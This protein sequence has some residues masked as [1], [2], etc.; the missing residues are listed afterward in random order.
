VTVCSPENDPEFI[1]KFSQMGIS[2]IP[3]PL[4]RNGMNPIQDIYALLFLVKT[5]L[6]IKPDIVFSA[7][8]K[9]VIYGSL[10]SRLA[11]VPRVFSMISGAGYA[12][13][14]MGFKRKLINLL[15]RILFSQALKNNV[16]VFF[17]NPD[18]LNLFVRLG[19]VRKEQT[20]RIN[21]EGVD[22][23]H[24]QPVPLPQ[25]ASVYLMICRLVKDKG[26]VEY[27]E[28]ARLVKSRYPET[29]FNLLGPY[30]SNN[31]SA[32]APSQIEK[33]QQEGIINYCG[34][35]NDVRPFLSESSVFVLPSYYEGT[36]RTTLEAMA[37]G[38]PILTTDVAGCRETVIEGKNGFLVPLRDVKALAEA[39]E[40]FIVDPDLILRMGK[41]S[42]EIVVQK[43]DVHKV[44]ARIMEVLGLLKETTPHNPS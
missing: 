35:T 38:R 41:A 37:T 32:L 15:V 36:P 23:E 40:R 27:V 44:N 30:D 11:R 29:T 42:R 39:M 10:A 7:S 43:F 5:L 24:F 19:L 25:T 13:V 1:E 2:F 14:E 3:F 26:V 22:L 18:D 21:G 31:T 34:E 8:T 33:W 17:L 12:F 6:K 16:S 20:V 28:A 9:P 4:S